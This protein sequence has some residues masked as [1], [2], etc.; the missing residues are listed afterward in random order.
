MVHSDEEDV[1]DSDFGSTSSGEDADEEDEEA[2]ERAQERAEA[3]KKNV[4]SISLPF[5][6]HAEAKLWSQA[7]KAAQRAARF[8]PRKMRMAQDA[9]RPSKKRRLSP[10]ADDPATTTLEQD[11]TLASELS[12]APLRRTTARATALSYIEAVDTRLAEEHAQRVANPDSGRGKVR[13]PTPKRLTQA[14]RIAEALETEELNKARLRAFYLAEEERRELERRGGL[15]RRVINDPK[16]IWLSRRVDRNQSVQEVGEED[17]SVET[18]PAQATTSTLAPAEHPL[19][20][21]ARQQAQPALSSATQPSAPAVPSTIPTT[22]PDPPPAPSSIPSTPI[23]GPS[24]VPAS[25]TTDPLPKPASS[26]LVP[27]ASPALE[28]PSPI[29]PVSAAG[30]SQRVVGPASA[31]DPVPAVPTPSESKDPAPSSTSISVPK[32]LVDSAKVNGDVSST[33]AEDPESRTYLILENLK[34]PTKTQERGAFFGTHTDWANVQAIPDK[35][36]LVGT[37]LSGSSGVRGSVSDPACRRQT[38]SFVRDHGP[39]GR[40]QGPS[41]GTSLRESRGL[42]DHQEGARSPIRLVLRV[43]VLH[44]RAGG[45]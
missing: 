10:S 44:R 25:A 18:R 36:R 35:L 32:V 38:R 23:P 6:C 13:A 34:N 21:L 20:A 43:P 40:V 5:E 8:L 37:L 30:P 2:I 16:V 24:S 19:D 39:T 14:E 26:F 15:I 29:S 1:F 41:H 7:M 31:S 9:E 12:Q 11:A 3:K 27:S 28:G 17:P 45:G 4:R 33:A 42:P 22:T